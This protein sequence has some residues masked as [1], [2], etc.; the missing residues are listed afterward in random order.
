MAST[1]PAP[2]ERCAPE[3]AD[4]RRARRRP[5]RKEDTGRVAGRSP[6]PDQ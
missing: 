3:W 6:A 1:P 2:F 4:H 5:D